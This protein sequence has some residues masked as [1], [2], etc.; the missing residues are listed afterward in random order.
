MVISNVKYRELICSVNTSVKDVKHTV[1]KSQKV[2]I[3]DNTTCLKV[4]S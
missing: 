1:L 4:N 2:L 3:V